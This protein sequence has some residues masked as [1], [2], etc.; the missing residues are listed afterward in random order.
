MKEEDNILNNQEE[1]NSYLQGL[2]KSMPY[3]VPVH[4]FESLSQIVWNKI[5][6][7]EETAALAPL[8]NSIGKQMPNAVPDNYFNTITFKASSAEKG[9]IVQLQIWKK[10]MVA[11][12][13]TG[14]I[15][16]SI[17]VWDTQRKNEFSVAIQHLNTEDLINQMDTSA[18]IF[19]NTDTDDTVTIMDVSET[20]DELKYASDD[21][22]Q[23][24]INDN[25]DTPYNNVE[26]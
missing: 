2:S 24:Y 21:D 23:E 15:F 9:R 16:T 17:S 14:I 8:L 5:Q 4:Y 6:L 26:I 1:D 22:L 11:A 13:I 3:S 20:Q 25:I 18:V 12:V 19:S 7:E 10:I